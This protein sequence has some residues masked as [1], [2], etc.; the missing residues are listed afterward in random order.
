[1]LRFARTAA[2]GVAYALT[3]IP[4]HA[5]IVFTIT[6]VGPNVAMSSS[7]VIDTGG[8]VLP[9]FVY[10]WGGAGIEENGNHDIMGGTT[11][12]DVD[13]SFGFNT[14][15]DLSQWASANG[16]W[17]SSNFT[18]IVNSGVKGF[19]TFVWSN[20]IQ[21]PGLGVARQDL[22]GSLWSPDQNW[23]FPNASFA[24]LNMFPGTY[25]VTDAVSGDSITFVIGA[26]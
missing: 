21:V 10:G 25:A 2:I 16:P 18:T 5:G 23:T 26:T 7:G 11:V 17:A 6:V 24:S 12:G 3:S 8:P 22:A 20:G 15:S 9:D 14:G 19:T 1:M 13:T 4:S